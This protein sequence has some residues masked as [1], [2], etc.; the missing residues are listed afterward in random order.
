MDFKREVKMMLDEVLHLEGRAST[1]DEKTVLLGSVPELDSMAVIA[2]I[3]AMEERF[4][5]S[6][7]DDEIDGAVFATLGSLIDFVRSKAAA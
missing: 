3:S 4:Q 2:V 6:V 1:F 7:D 5:C